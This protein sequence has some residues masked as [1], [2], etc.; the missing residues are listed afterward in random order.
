MRIKKLMMMAL[1]LFGFSTLN[2]LA[3]EPMLIAKYLDTNGSV[4][5]THMGVIEQDEL[6]QKLKK[7]GVI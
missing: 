1:T 3:D 5:D 6:E 4:V 7:L 2:A